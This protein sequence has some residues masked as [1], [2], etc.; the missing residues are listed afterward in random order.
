MSNRGVM[1]L[2]VLLLGLPL[3]AH[4]GEAIPAS[5]EPTPAPNRGPDLG[6]LKMLKA[7]QIEA[8]DRRIN[9]LQVAYEADTDKEGLLGDA[10]S[11]VTVPD[12]ELEDAF[13]SWL[14][15]HPSSY[16]AN[17]AT[18]WYYL[19][20][21]GAW[22][23]SKFIK[24]TPQWKLDAMDR[25]LQKAVLILEQSVTMTEK[26]SES[27]ALLIN[28]ARLRGR[29]KEASRWLGEAT[30]RDPYCILPR[31]EYMAHLEPRSLSENSWL[32]VS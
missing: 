32:H 20:M 17:L 3:L 15:S 28:A 1:I 5:S 7:G 16:A 10:L 29:I 26:P 14:A 18:G 21:A 13:Q 22:R 31:N 8:L 30:R 9:D 25:Y 19:N 11:V 6:P 12:P 4:A 24:D 2:I 23:G 27:Y